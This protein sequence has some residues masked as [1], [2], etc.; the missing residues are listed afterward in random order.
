MLEHSLVTFI[1]DHFPA[2]AGRSAGRRVRLPVCGIPKPAAHEQPLSII[3]VVATALRGR[4]GR[5]S[6]RQWYRVGRHDPLFYG[7]PAICRRGARCWIS[8]LNLMGDRRARNVGW[9]ERADAPA[10]PAARGA[11]ASAQ[12]R[13]QHRPRL[14][15]PGGPVAP[16]WKDYD[17]HRREQ[18]RGVVR[19]GWR[20]RS[21]RTSPGQQARAGV[22]RISLGSGSRCPRRC[23][24]TPRVNETKKGVS[25]GSVS[26]DIDYEDGPGGHGGDARARRGE[27]K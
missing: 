2:I 16:A 21:P 25:V 20:Q 10:H 8:P 5:G 24:P 14:L 27:S 7:T 6:V 22:P 12:H 18:D 9:D 4:L 3:Y 17:M 13:S 23:T 11:I 26:V 19:R 1:R 15:P